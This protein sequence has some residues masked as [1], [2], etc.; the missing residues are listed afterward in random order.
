MTYLLTASGL[1]FD[2]LNPRSEM[3]DIEDI[4]LAL[5]RE[6]RFVGHTRFFHS[7]AAHSLLAAML[8]PG[9]FKLEA[10]LHD[11]AEAYLKDIPT[12][13]KALLPEYR[14]IEAR[15]DAVIRRKF[16]LP[17]SCSPEVTCIDRVL[18]ATERRDLI[19]PDDTEWP[20]LAG[21]VPCPERVKPADMED[22][23]RAFL[24]LYWELR[25]GI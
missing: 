21:V 17:D 5:S 15:V 18:L 11:A 22:M 12:P 19:P 2:L 7:V 9:E 3:I 25:K 13:L 1:K 8:A 20:G 24:E 23:R 6:P 14:A 4:A 10:L 16:G